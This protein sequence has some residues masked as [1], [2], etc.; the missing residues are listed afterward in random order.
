MKFSVSS[1]T[2]SSRLQAVSRVINPKSVN[3]ILQDVLFKTEGNIL[4][5][6]ASD[7]D[8]TLETTVEL[9]ESDGNAQIALPAKTMLDALKEIPEQPLTFQI[10]DNTHETIVV[11]LNGQYTIMG[12]DADEYPQPSVLATDAAVHTIPA[13][14]F[15][16]GI[17]RC[18]FA[19]AEDELRPVMNGVFID[20]ETEYTAFVASDGH[21]LVCDKTSA[22]KSSER[23]SVILPKRPTSL[24]KSLMGNE[25][26]VT[27]TFDNRSAM[28]AVS[29]YRMVCRLI[30]GRYPNYNSVIPANN[31]HKLTIDRTTLISALKRVSVFSPASSGLIKLRV[32]DN[33]LVIST[34]DLDFS[35]SATETLSCQ[36]EGAPMNIGFKA[37]FLI[38][39]LSNTPGQEIVLKLAD[40]SRAGVVVPCEQEENDDLLMLLMPMVLND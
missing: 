11:Y 1:S 35:T 18:L 12:H 37:G 22:Y 19:V 13:N 17:T 32:K 24:L 21:K 23:A 27:L 26:D 38:D 4:T 10:D 14:V 25:G 31:P 6:V 30:E 36:Y 39:I 20:L 29:D 16:T 28:I 2:L 8:T 7:N 9:A 3:P 34:Q 40:P 15:S 5:I 33:Q